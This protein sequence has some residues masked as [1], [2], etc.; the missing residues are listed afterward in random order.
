MVQSTTL[1]LVGQRKQDMILVI[2]K[3]KLG[4]KQW[5]CKYSYTPVEMVENM[6]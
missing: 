6:V 5:N 2:D 1:Y 3:R 4:G